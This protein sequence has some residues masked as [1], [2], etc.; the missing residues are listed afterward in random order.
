M[1]RRLGLSRRGTRQ[2]EAS[3][4]KFEKEGGYMSGRIRTRETY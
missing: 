2:D 1:V 4:L 3:Q